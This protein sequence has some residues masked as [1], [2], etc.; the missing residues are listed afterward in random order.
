MQ[1]RD[2]KTSGLS[3]DVAIN[4]YWRINS[5]VKAKVG[6]SEWVKPKHWSKLE[7][8]ID[9]ATAAGDATRALDA[10]ARY[11]EAVNAWDVNPVAKPKQEVVDDWD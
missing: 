1:V 8:T 2:G 11:E 10:L 9:A 6:S 4:G 5:I 7:D 3:R